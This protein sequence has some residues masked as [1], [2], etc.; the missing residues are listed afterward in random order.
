M[1]DDGGVEARAWGGETSAPTSELV[2]M[3]EQ[4]DKPGPSQAL[5]KIGKRGP[6]SGQL[7]QPFQSLGL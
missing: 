7:G 5:G 2:F 3:Y 4:T 1:K 6:S